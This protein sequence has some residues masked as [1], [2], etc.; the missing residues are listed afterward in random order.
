MA[1]IEAWSQASLSGSMGTL[2]RTQSNT[3][4]ISQWAP[5]CSVAQCRWG[6]GSAGVPARY[7]ETAAASD[8][9]W[10][11]A[12]VPSSSSDTRAPGTPKFPHLGMGGASQHGARR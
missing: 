7:R 2:L 4:E 9:L 6:W 12:L 1:G 11:C 3:W 10:A 5:W 8:W